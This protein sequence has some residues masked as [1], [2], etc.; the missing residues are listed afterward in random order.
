MTRA[1]YVDPVVV[2]SGLSN[3]RLLGIFTVFEHHCHKVLRL[4]HI[5]TRSLVTVHSVSG[6]CNA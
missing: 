6:L 1:R 5:V 3:L 2:F 4:I